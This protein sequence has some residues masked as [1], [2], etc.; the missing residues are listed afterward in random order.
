MEIPLL[1]SSNEENGVGLNDFDLYVMYKIQKII[2]S[3][4]I[5]KYLSAPLI[6]GLQA[7][8]PIYFVSVV[9]TS[10]SPSHHGRVWL[11]PVISLPRKDKNL[12][13]SNTPHLP[14]FQKSAGAQGCGSGFGFNRVFGSGSGFGIRIQEGKNDP[15]K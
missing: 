14:Q 9:F 13:Y 7:T 10:G 11:L 3:P 6:K 4:N 1:S 8:R 5:W 15:Q 12:L 2:K